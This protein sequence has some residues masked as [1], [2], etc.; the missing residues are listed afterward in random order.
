MYFILIEQ[1]IAFVAQLGHMS[2]NL[3]LL[4]YHLHQNSILYVLLAMELPQISLSL[5]SEMIGAKSIQWCHVCHQSFTQG[6]SVSQSKIEMQ[7]CR[8]FIWLNWSVWMRC[9]LEPVPPNFSDSFKG[10]KLL[11]SSSDRNSDSF[12]FF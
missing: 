12:L 8:H 9:T 1:N 5:S 10:Q 2:S 3:L 4:S 7:S 11:I 6:W